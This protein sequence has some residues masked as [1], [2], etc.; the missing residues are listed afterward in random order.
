MR[1]PLRRGRQGYLG[2]CALTVADKLVEG[3]EEKKVRDQDGGVPDA[4]PLGAR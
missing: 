3:G 2:G 4:L 1:K